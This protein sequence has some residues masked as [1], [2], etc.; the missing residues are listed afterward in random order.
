MESTPSGVRMTIRVTPRAS[1]NEVRGLDAG[2]RLVVRVTA[3]PVDG[4]ANQAVIELLAKWARVSKSSV[5]VVRGAASRTKTIEI[6]GV[7]AGLLAER[8][9]RKEEC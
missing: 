7:D 1:A 6:S 8:L 9:T 4:D 5:R 3:P 2:G